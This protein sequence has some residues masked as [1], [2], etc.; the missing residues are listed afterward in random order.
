[1]TAILLFLWKSFCRINEKDYF[2]NEK[3]GANP[4]RALHADKQ[5]Y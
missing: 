5:Y 3:K 2:Y 4:L 1:M